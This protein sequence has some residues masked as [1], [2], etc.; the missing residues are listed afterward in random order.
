[1]FKVE[2]IHHKLLQRLLKYQ[3]KSQG[4]LFMFIPHGHFTWSVSFW[5]GICVLI[6]CV[7]WD[8]DVGAVD[9][10]QFRRDLKTYLFARRYRIRGVT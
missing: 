7:Q 10:E 9:S 5:A 6:S 3:Q 2:Y 8:V 1:M 4:L